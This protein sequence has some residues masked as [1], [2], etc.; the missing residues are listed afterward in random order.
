LITTTSKKSLIVSRKTEISLK[1]GKCGSIEAFRSLNNI[2]D[3]IKYNDEN[4]LVSL[5]RMCNENGEDRVLAFIEAYLVNVNE[6]LNMEVMPKLLI[7]QTALL[8]VDT[9]KAMLTVADIDLFF[10]CLKRGDYGS[11]GVKLDGQKILMWLA[12]Y[13]DDK[14]GKVEDISYSQHLSTKIGCSH[15]DRVMESK[16]DAR[17]AF[18][19]ANAYDIINTSQDD[20]ER[21]NL[22]QEDND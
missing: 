1:F 7:Q 11:A 10:K 17:R 9:Y 8:I 22:T 16:D 4:K 5:G 18:D 19:I 3:V 20:R 12:K 2:S 15:V 14:S 13:W 6:F 21:R